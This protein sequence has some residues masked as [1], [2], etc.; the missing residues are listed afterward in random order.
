MQAFSFIDGTHLP[1]KRPV[2]DP[3]DFLNYKGYHSLSVQAVCDCRGEFMD[4]ECRW[5][6]NV[7]DAKMF[8]KFSLLTKLKIK[9]CLIHFKTLHKAPLRFLTI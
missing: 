9:N 4:V 5:P 8:A 2:K 7:H 1:I 6:G 3:Q